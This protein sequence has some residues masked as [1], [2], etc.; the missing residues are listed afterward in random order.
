MDSYLEG[1]D[2]EDH[3]AAAFW[4]LQ[5]LIHTEEMIKRGLLPK[6]LNDLPVY[7]KGAKRD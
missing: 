7:I 5:G 2:S 6:A 4:N 1:E 3:L